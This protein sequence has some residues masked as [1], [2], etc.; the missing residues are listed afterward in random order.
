M[1]YITTLRE[2]YERESISDKPQ[3]FMLRYEAIGELLQQFDNMGGLRIQA[4][5][6]SYALTTDGRLFLVQGATLTLCKPEAPVEPSA[7]QEDDWEAA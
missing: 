7:T 2:H 6:G 1:D 5:I 3:S 4:V